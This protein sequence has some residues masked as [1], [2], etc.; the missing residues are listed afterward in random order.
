MYVRE[1]GCPMVDVCV[2]EPGWPISDVY[3]RLGDSYV[4]LGDVYVRESGHLIQKE[5]TGEV[6]PKDKN[7]N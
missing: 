4:G 2:T 6:H 1:S 7:Q 5:T 3:V